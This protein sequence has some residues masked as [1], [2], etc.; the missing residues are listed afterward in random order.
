MNSLDGVIT[1]NKFERRVW[2]EFHLWNTYLKYYLYF[3]ANSTDVPYNECG[4]SVFHYKFQD[5]LP[6]SCIFHP[7]T[8]F[9]FIRCVYLPPFKCSYEYVTTMKSEF[10]SIPYLSGSNKSPIPEKVRWKRVVSWK[11]KK[12]IRKR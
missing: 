5:M 10:G 1:W 11:K 3:F 12:I 8:R 9:S 4:V 7:K 6:Y 2:F